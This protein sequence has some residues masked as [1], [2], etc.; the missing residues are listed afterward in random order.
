[1]SDSRRPRVERLSIILNFV[2]FVNTFFEFFL[3]FFR[4]GS[5]VSFV[6]ILSAV[7]VHLAQKTRV[8][9]P[10]L[11]RDAAAV[12]RACG[13]YYIPSAPYIIYNEEKGPPKQS[14][15]I[16]QIFNQMYFTTRS[17]VFESHWSPLDI[18]F[19]LSSVPRY[20]RLFKP[21]QSENAPSPMDTRH[22]PR[23]TSAR[24]AHA[25]NAKSPIVS[26]KLGTVLTVTATR[27]LH[28]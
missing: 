12:M 19:Q 8:L 5:F 16:V 10:P 17:L 3:T 11:E 7:F 25:A 18:A 13:L 6:P 15:F 28:P 21:V 23:V 20:W 27:L 24:L 4:F 26:T 22:S 9:K 14:L 1:M 2:L